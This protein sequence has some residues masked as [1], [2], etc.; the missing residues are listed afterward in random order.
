MTEYEIKI[1]I[2]SETDVHSIGHC[3]KDDLTKSGYS[4]GAIEWHPVWGRKFKGIKM[5]HNA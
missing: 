4:V 1:T 5:I 3:I 2:D